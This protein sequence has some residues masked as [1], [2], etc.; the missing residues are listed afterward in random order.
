MEKLIKDHFAAVHTNRTASRHRDS[1]IEPKLLDS[2]NQISPPLPLNTKDINTEK[3]E[4]D[5][6]ACPILLDLYQLP[7]REI[8]KS[9]LQRSVRH[10]V[11]IARN[12][13]RN[14][15]SRDRYWKAYEVKTIADSGS[16]LDFMM[17]SRGLIDIQQYEPAILVNLKYSTPDNILAEDMYGTLKKAYVLPQVAAML[18]RANRKL[19]LLHPGYALCIYDAAR[20][21]SIQQKLWDKVRGTP[22]EKYVADPS[23]LSLHN[24]GAAVDLTIVDEKGIPLD[25]GTEFDELSPESEPRLERKMLKEGRLQLDQVRNRMLLR[26]VMKRGGFAPIKDEWWHFTAFGLTKAKWRHSVIN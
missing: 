21:L 18:K 20:P 1:P 15:F 9:R 8:S 17:R 4:R 12:R 7:H 13:C 25:M 26:R 3:L 19:Q 6:G 14:Y 5:G 11:R 10:L 16:N 2:A 22:M 23:K 24:F